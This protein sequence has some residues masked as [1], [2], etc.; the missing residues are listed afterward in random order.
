MAMQEELK[1]YPFG[2]VWEEYCKQ[3]GVA[4]GMDWFEEVKAYEKDVL[5][6]R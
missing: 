2:D 3:C 1:M 5:L 4:S 6:K